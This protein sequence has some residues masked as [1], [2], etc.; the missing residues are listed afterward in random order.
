MSLTIMS[1]SVK[2]KIGIN[3]VV[4]KILLEAKIEIHV[5]D[6]YVKLCENENWNQ[7]CSHQNITVVHCSLINKGINTI[8]NFA[9]LDFYYFHRK[10]LAKDFNK[11]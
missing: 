9:K 8:A 5:L 1:S 10:V 4:T 6:N 3:V 11:K 7:C 2:M